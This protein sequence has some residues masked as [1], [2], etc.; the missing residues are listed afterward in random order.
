MVSSSQPW[1][2]AE[3]PLR[4]GHAGHGLRPPSVEGQVGDHLDELLL[5]CAALLGK[6]EVEYELVDVP[7]RR[8]RRD[9]HEAALL[10]R[11]LGARPDLS[12]QDVVG[13]ATSAGAKSPSIL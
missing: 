1:S 11:Q 9:G 7:A 6:A 12:E 8:Q 3:D 13:E 2:Q 4:D 10:R 5:G